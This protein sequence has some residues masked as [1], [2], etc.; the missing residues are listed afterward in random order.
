M[1]KYCTLNALILILEFAT[2]VLVLVDESAAPMDI[3]VLTFAY[4]CQT[5]PVLI[6]IYRPS[7][8]KKRSFP[9]DELNMHIAAVIYAFSWAVDLAN[10]FMT[11]Y[12]IVPL[13]YGMHIRWDFDDVTSEQLLHVIER[14]HAARGIIAV[15][16]KVVAF[17][18]LLTFFNHTLVEQKQLLIKQRE[19]EAKKATQAI[20]EKE[21]VMSSE[22]P[23]QS[24]T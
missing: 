10:Y 21:S 22:E 14:G 23:P 16:I 19:D 12:K 7:D 17:R 15:I 6:A 13:V 20:S 2:C 24:D 18:Y 9:T 8:S 1:G 3:K 5:V 4:L 11:A